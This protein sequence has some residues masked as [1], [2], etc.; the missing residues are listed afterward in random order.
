MNIKILFLFFLSGISTSI[1]NAQHQEVYISHYLFPSFIQ[2]KIK[3]KDGSIT[4]TN[5]NY[6]S[7]TEEMIFDSKG[8]N[9]AIANLDNVDTVEIQGR[10]FIPSGKVFYEILVN[11]PIPLFA[12]H[13]CRVTPPGNPSGYGGTSETAAIESRSRLYSSGTVYELKLPSDY[14]IDPYYELLIKKDDAYYKINNVNQLIKCIPEKKV[15]I[16]EYVKS[17]KTNFKKTDDV[18]NIVIFCNK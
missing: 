1:L 3:L 6:N 18:K 10:L 12:H 13:L 5:L 17:H 7:I 14:K 11:L 8:T 2:G 15:A 16:Q 9:L 4:T